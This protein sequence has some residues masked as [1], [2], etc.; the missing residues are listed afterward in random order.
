MQTFRLI[1]IFVLA[2]G[3]GESSQSPQHIQ[4]WIKSWS[5]MGMYLPDKEQVD[6]LRA[7][8]DDVSQELAAALDHKN[9]DVRQRA[10]YVIGEIGP[11]AESLGP[12]LASR[13]KIEKQRLVRIYLVDALTTVDFGDEETVG[14]LKSRFES[15]SSENVAQPIG[16]Y[17]DVDEKIN[18]AAALNNMTTG[19]EREK[20]LEF[21]TKWLRPPDD[22]LSV[23]EKE[24]YWERRW[25]A[26]ICLEHMDG[27][28]T[29]I[30]LLEAMLEEGDVRSWVHH[31]VPR[32]L[33]ALKNRGG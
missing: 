27:T 15:L 11:A 4:A 24:N 13:L 2:I 6:F 5:E 29:A 31:H 30:P 23:A 10:A 3:C 12:A 22:Q 21:V 33:R 20:Y 17:A 9:P 26:V 18:V 7:N 19:A 25:V 16:E 28:T 32:V 1:L 8:F 14:L